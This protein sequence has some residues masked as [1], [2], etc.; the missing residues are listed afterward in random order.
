MIDE[1]PNNHWTQN[2]PTE[3]GSYWHWN[4]DADS[5][6]IHIDIM[7]SGTDGKSFAPMGQYGWTEAQDVDKLG[8]WWMVLVVPA[9]PVDKG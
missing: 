7:W 4:G 9:L 6:P 8:G 1:N 5:A 3:S 2:V